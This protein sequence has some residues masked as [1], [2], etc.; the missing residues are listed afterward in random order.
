[1]VAAA[2]AAA[3]LA[4]P[5]PSQAAGPTAVAVGADGSVYAGFASGAV[6]RHR[7]SDGV[8][9]A[10]WQTQVADVDGSLGGIV[11]LDGSA[12][13]GVWVLDSNRRVQEFGR[14]GSF[15]RGFS[16]SPCEGSNDPAP[17]SK[18]G[19]EVT[20]SA[21]YVAHPCANSVERF[22]LADL[23]SAGTGTPPSIGIGVFA[24]HGIAAPLSDTAA[25][26]TQALYVT[27]P[28][29][30]AIRRFDLTTLAQI[31]DSVPITHTGSPEDVHLSGEAGQGRILVSEAANA[32]PGY[33][34]RAYAFS[35]AGGD[36]YPELFNF[37]GL[38]TEPGRLNGAVAMEGA[39]VT[40][41][42]ATEVVIADRSNERL[43]RLT[44][45]AADNGNVIWVAAAQDPGPPPQPGSGDGSGGGSGDE[46]PSRNPRI[47][48]NAGARYTAKPDVLLTLDEPR[49]TESIE[50]ANDAGFE[51][52][53]RFDAGSDG[54]GWRLESEDP[55]RVRRRVF[56]R[57]QGSGR[58]VVSDEIRLDRGRPKIRSARVIDGRNGPVLSVIAAD[59]GSGLSELR[60]AATRKGPFQEQSFEFRTPLEAKRDARFVRV[61]DLVGNV[62]ALER[63]R[64][65]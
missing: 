9:V 19:L 34:H 43:Q 6:K 39:A 56:V 62:S 47:Q 52:G 1:M 38:G 55:D 30:S 10:T 57:F 14:D 24:P 22:A 37:G 49:G 18:G 20:T 63:S 44:A 27:Q 48:I 54:I 64:R 58:R 8:A 33:A 12:A 3:A 32:D 29:S 36:S 13:G 4:A 51:T 50:I 26:D 41:G 2:L 7:G 40:G 46:G 45:T 15:V 31:G 11:A 16:L 42:L 21:V 65:R 35:A 5:A 61:A 28:Q 59:A 17:G 60:F 23:P 25:S 53:K